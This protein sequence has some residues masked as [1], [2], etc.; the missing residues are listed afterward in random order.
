[1][2]I[3]AR[4]K[5]IW[6]ELA[7]TGVVSVYYFYNSFRLSGWTEIASYEMGLLVRDVIILSIVASI[8]LYA[9]F[10]RENPEQ[11]DERDSAIESR[12]N[13]FAYYSL[14][15]LCCLL[16]GTIMLSE[17][18]FLLGKT[19]AINGPVVMHLLL[20]AL[21]IAALIKQ[22]TQLFFYRRG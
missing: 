11:K 19:S 4:E 15:V 10:A 17:G 22:A 12:G 1:M 3:S 8:A 6:I 7:I 14:T 5:N 13:A 9:L 18:I 20:I 21:M 2:D 16:I